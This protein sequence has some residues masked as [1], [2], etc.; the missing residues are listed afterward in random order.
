M[1]ARNC[2]RNW[3]TSASDAAAAAD[4]DTAAAAAAAAAAD[5]SRVPMLPLPR[6]DSAALDV[7]SASLSPGGEAPHSYRDYIPVAA[8]P[9]APTLIP[10]GREK[11][12]LPAQE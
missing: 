11:S 7:C 8:V 2:L 10:G 5:V 12:H 9:D 6:P 3:E 1:V 4:T